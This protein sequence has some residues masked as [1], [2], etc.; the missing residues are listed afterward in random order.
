MIDR[1]KFLQ[2]SVAAALATGAPFGWAIRTAGAVPA[3]AGL[4]NPAL[5]PMFVNLVPDALAPSFKYVP[6]AAGVYK[7][8]IREGLQ[9]TGL[10][11]NGV[12]VPTPVWGYADALA[13]NKVATW[14]GKTFEVIH[15]NA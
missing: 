13:G 3:A 12:N 8:E 6:D 2:A 14:P 9:Y 5:Q 10:Q 11:Q 15:D 7:V 1:R 4:S